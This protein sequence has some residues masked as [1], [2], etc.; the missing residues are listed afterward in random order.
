MRLTALVALLAALVLGGCSGTSSATGE[1]PG[2][3]PSGVTFREPPASAPAAP[4]FELTLADGDVVDMT[5]QW[6][7]RPVVLVFFE[8]WC[9]L[10]ADQQAEIN[11][12]A[13]DYRDVILFVGIAGTSDPADID[14]YI[15]DHD[16]SYPIGIDASQRTWL[17]YAASEPPLVALISK[18]GRL[19]RGWPGGV[20]SADLREQIEQLVIDSR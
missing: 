16:V 3:V 19:L 5:E 12:V 11:D 13:G 15:A 9:T 14:E 7:Q 2:A 1:L 10:C 6:A 17:Q 20:S 18:G 4:A 8:S